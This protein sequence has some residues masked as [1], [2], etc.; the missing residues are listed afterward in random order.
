MSAAGFLYGQDIHHLDHI[1]PL[2]HFLDIPLVV[3]EP[4]M[5][6]TTKHYY[7]SVVVY[8]YNTLEV[9]QHTLKQFD[10]I[11]SCL[12]TAMIDQIFFF[13]EHLMRKKILNIWLGHGN[14]DKGKAS[15][16]MEA[17]QHEKIALVYGQNMIDF[18]KEKQVLDKLFRHIPIGNYRYHYY[19]KMRPFYDKIVK[20]NILS[21]FKKDQ[22][23]L[24]YAPTWGK[25]SNESSF[26]SALPQILH[27]LPASYNLIVKMHPNS[28]LQHQALYDSLIK[29]YARS[30]NVLFLDTFPPIYPLL[31]TI[32]ILLGDFSSINYDFL[33]FQKPMF[34]LNPTK[35]SH[36]ENPELTLHQCGTSIHA[37][38]FPN[39][40]SILEKKLPE[41]TMLYKTKRACFYEYTFAP[42]D[43]YE[44][45]KNTIKKTINDYFEEEIH[46]L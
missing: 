43:D 1:A 33:T 38:D 16:F 31:S 44:M 27:S 13:D 19:M 35:T 4:E 17:L 20:K 6:K 30:P 40:F 11:F 15:P 21:K 26:I 29:K 10:V 9:A 28:I 39:I 2:C 5:E 37:E 32:D 24:M 25:T 45:V 22:T 23:T 12:P 41:D 34:F 14:S 46:T 7:P 8:C 18:L 36:I 3:T 42:I